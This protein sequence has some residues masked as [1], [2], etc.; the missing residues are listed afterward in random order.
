MRPYAEYFGVYAQHGPRPLLAFSAADATLPFLTANDEMWQSFQLQLETRL[1]DLDATATA[2]DRVRAV[3]LELLPSGVASLEATAR[4]LGTSVR[5]LQR[6]LQR[7]QQSFQGV[8]NRTRQDLACHYLKTSDMTCA[9]ISFLLG[10]EDPNSF[11]RAF[12]AW[13]GQT[14]ER[15]REK[16]QGPD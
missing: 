3:L 15:L 5:T 9:E 11:F 10:F 6:R 1:A 2:T 4:R 14:P 13:T 12:Q 16:L 8:L 7:E